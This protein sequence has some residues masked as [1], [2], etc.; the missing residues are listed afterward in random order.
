M[1]DATVLL[2]VQVPVRGQFCR[3]L[4]CI[5]LQSYLAHAAPLIF[6]RRNKCLVVVPCPLCGNRMMWTDVI[7]DG[8]GTFMAVNLIHQMIHLQLGCI[9]GTS[10]GLWHRT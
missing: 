5:D 6:A 1:C 9:S 8:L 7:C 4:A 3:H 10:T 2:C